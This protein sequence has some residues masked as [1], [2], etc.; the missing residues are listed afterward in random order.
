MLSYFADRIRLYDRMRS[1]WPSAL[2][3]PYRRGT[4][5]GC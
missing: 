3:T 2:A 5:T 1:R 4:M